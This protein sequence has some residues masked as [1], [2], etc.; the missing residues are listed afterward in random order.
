MNI[1]YLI[2]GNDL[3]QQDID[4]LNNWLLTTQKHNSLLR[5]I[6][7]FSTRKPNYYSDY[8][9]L[10]V[11]FKPNKLNAIQMSIVEACGE[12]IILTT[13]NNLLSDTD[14]KLSA[15]LPKNT[16]YHIGVHLNSGK[17]LSL[18]GIRRL[19]SVPFIISNSEF[20]KNNSELFENVISAIKK[21]DKD[22]ALLKLQPQHIKLPEY[23][24]KRSIFSGPYA[25]IIKYR[26]LNHKKSLLD[27]FEKRRV[28]RLR[29]N[30]PPVKFSKNIP[31]FIICRDRVEPL[32][33]LVKWFEEEGLKNIY[34]IDNASTYPKLLEYFD[35]TPY[36]VIS[37]NENIGHTSPWVSGA[38]KIFAKNQPFIVT[39]PDIIPTSNSLGAVRHF[40]NL[41]TKY[42]ERTKV[43]FGLKIDDLPDT[44]ELKDY[45]IEWE[46]QFWVS[47]VE[48]EVFDAEID[49]TFAVYRQNTPYTLGPGLRTGGK[50]VAR[51][52]PWYINSEKLSVEVMYYRSHANKHISTWGTNQ[53]E[54]IDTYK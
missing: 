39:D 33:K 41:L 40:C 7:I 27:Y 23:I 10:S 25:S 11:V 4:H 53:S 22:I 43:G 3:S 26:Y 49:T 9:N 31:V 44:Y 29:N 42:P 54:L 8:T 13:C 19:N 34:F 17:L 48:N 1:T 37:L 6:I 46:N 12:H 36:E 32:K 5:E 20:A 15:F 52:E 30:V 47:S 45:V 28:Q 16:N 21:A 18:L 24:V 50:L 51:H 2:G 38:T 35:K 14:D